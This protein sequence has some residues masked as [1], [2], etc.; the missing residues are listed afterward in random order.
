MKNIVILY[1]V[2]GL[3][4]VGRHAILA[5]LERSMDTNNDDD[6]GH[7]TIL[8]QHPNLI[9]DDNTD[10]NCGCNN[11]PNHQ[12]T[13]DHIQQKITIVPIESSWKETDLSPYLQGDNTT[14]ISCVGNRQPFFGHYDATEANES[15]I[16]AM[17]KRQND[18]SNGNNN[19]NN[20][21]KN[22]SFRVIV[23]TSCGVNEDWPALEFF[24]IGRIAMFIIFTMLARTMYRDLST[25]E[26]LYQSSPDYIDYLF[27]RPV[28]LSEDVQP[29]NQ[30]VIQTQKYKHPL[31]IEMSK[32]D[33]ARYMVEE[34][35]QP[36]RHRDAVVIG[37]DPNVP[38]LRT[39]KQTKK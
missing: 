15:L 19:N 23:M 24:I 26:R 12:L 28:G 35:L 4:D 2:G 13:E 7:I 38:V 29:I 21:N 16:R 32:L 5:G 8:T 6:I 36:T 17:T 39:T 1:G 33:V 20:N 34:A 30:W 14:I 37:S 11:Q 27:I 22:V 31:G 3:A 25:M 10:W 9:T 18:E